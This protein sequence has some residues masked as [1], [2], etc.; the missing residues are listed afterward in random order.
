MNLNI[1]GIDIAK[2]QFDIF[3]LNGQTHTTRPNS[4][5]GIKGL[6]KNLTKLGEYIAEHVNAAKGPKAMALPLGGLDNYFRE[7]SQWHGTDVS[8]LFDAIRANLD[9]GIELLEM[10][11]NIN[12]EPFADAVF[13]LFME[14]WNQRTGA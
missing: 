14:R 13:N 5:Q 7:G 6:V 10:D 12:D 2:A 9:D 4:P 8:N 11:N 1:I 3:E